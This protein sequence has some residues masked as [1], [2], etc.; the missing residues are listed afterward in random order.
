MG[1]VSYKLKSF[2]YTRESDDEMRIEYDYVVYVETE[3]TYYPD[4]PPYEYPHAKSISLNIHSGDIT[5][6]KKDIFLLAN[7]RNSNGGRRYKKR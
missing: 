1:H 5:D 3:F 6:L 2:T 7:S 4:N